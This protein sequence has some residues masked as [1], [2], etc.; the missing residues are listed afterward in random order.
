[1][2]RWICCCKEKGSADLLLDTQ[3]SGFY[4]VFDPD[5]INRFKFFADKTQ[6]YKIVVRLTLNNC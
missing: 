5:L 1:M 6:A 4:L 2:M 3:L